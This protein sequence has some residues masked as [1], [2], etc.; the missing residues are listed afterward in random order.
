MSNNWRLAKWSLG[1]SEW[2]VRRAGLALTEGSTDVSTPVPAHSGSEGE[3]QVGDA[4]QTVEM[5]TFDQFG[6]SVEDVLPDHWMQDFM[7][8]S[9]FNQLADGSSR[10]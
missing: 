5:S 9:F 7:S 6:F 8:E 4:L 10:F 1:V 3:Q 2:V